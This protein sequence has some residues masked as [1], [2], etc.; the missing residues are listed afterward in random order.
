[1]DTA[2]TAVID[3]P[4]GSNDLVCE[5]LILVAFNPRVHSRPAAGLPAGVSYRVVQPKPDRRILLNAAK[6]ILAEL[7]EDQSDIYGKAAQRALEKVHQ[8]A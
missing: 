1:M 2:I 6:A 4:G 8:K 3:Y 7:A 5:H